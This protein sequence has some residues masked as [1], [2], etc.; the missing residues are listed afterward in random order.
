[1]LVDSAKAMIDRLEEAQAESA[2][3]AASLRDA[4]A[5]LEQRVSDRTESLREANR[6]LE[7]HVE[8]LR[9]ARSQLADAARKAGMAEVAS[10]VLHNVGNVLNSVNVSTARLA[11]RLRGSERPLLDMALAWCCSHTSSASRPRSPGWSRGRLP[12]Y[13][14][15]ALSMMPA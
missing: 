1:M 7:E 9:Q 2:A 4:N 3:A 13:G 5:L 14:C 11:D 6:A 10:S 15:P 12:W 8:R